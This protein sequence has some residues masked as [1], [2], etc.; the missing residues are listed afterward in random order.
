MTTLTEAFAKYGAK[1]QNVQ[2]AVSAVS[3][4]DELVMSLWQHYFKKHDGPPPSLRYTDTL[5][6]WSGNK[7]GNSLC[8]E[9]LE[10]AKTENLR[11]R[12]VIARTKE[13]DAIDRGDDVSSVKKTFGARPD[14]VGQLT[15]F[16]G[17]EFVIDFMRDE[18]A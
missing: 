11:I 4:H 9:H 10:R 2:W 14:L 15:S 5:S 16:D 7:A 3:K 18:P 17:D 1:L 13:T 12:L 6:R 8:R